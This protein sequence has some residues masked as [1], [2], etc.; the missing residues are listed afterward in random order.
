[1]DEPRFWAI[2]EAGG[3]YCLDDQERQMASVRHQ[4]LELPPAQVFLFYCQFFRRIVDAQIW[5]L[6]GAAYR[7]NGGRSEEGLVPFLAWL[8]SQ[9]RVVYT[10]VVENPDSLASVIDPTRDDYGFERL[11]RLA[12]QV[13]FEHTRSDV[14]RTGVNWPP[15]P[16]G[17]PWASNDAAELT[18]RLPRLAKLYRGKAC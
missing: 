17:D 14:P 12:R 5:D 4:L 7:I 15:G 18:G 16:R 1:M 9:G 8:V 6:Y 11:F 2:I 13:Y 10:M 3:P